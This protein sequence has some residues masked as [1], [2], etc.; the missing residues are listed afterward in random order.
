[1]KTMRRLEL[2]L[3]I[4]VL[5]CGGGDVSDFGQSIPVQFGEWVMSGDDAVYDRE[6][7]YDY[8]NG[9]AEVYLS[10]DFRDVWV[11]RFVGPNGDEIALDV[12]D[13]GSAPEAFG[14]YSTS[15][16][17][18]DAGIG[19]GS[20][21][22]A[23]LLKFWK[24]EYFVSVI[25]MGVDESTDP[26]LLDIGR[27]VEAAIATD[28]P[29][30]DL[31]SALPEA[32]LN[33]RQTTFF[34]SDVILNNRYFIASENVLHLDGETDCV[35]A[36]Y[37]P[38]GEDGKLLLVQ[39]GNEMLAQEAFTEFKAAYMPEAGEDNRVQGENGL[40]TMAERLDGMI[41]IVFEAP[42]EERAVELMSHVEAN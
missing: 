32:G 13:M 12:Y 5:S 27:A 16:E 26:V 24:G 2:L 28:G 21:F 39:Y 1:M 6:T 17:D 22:G 7:L 25:N 36:E 34:H 40:W 37:G 14:V 20:E 38:A 3:V 11:R 4:G 9:G 23:G 29:E 10:Y 41:A 31:V 19:Q 33:I 18:P 30:P 42:D 15:V 8:M 35:F